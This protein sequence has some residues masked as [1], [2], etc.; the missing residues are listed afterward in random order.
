MGETGTTTKLFE[1]TLAQVTSLSLDFFLLIAF[2]IVFTAYTFYFGKGRAATFII[3]L[4]VSTFLYLFFPY[5][6]KLKG[7]VE[8][9][10]GTIGIELSLF[11]A[12]LIITNI[13]I[14]RL[15]GGVFSV[16]TLYSWFEGILLSISGTV[17]VLIFSYHIIPITQIYDFSPYLDA[18]FEP[19]EYLFFWL[20]APLLALIFVSRG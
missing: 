9:E 14:G 7:L 17:L 10:S 11:I 12:F 4:Y 1:N 16:S 8:T 19:A 2:F 6:E 13:I 15:I 20:S 18:L 5:F 3:S